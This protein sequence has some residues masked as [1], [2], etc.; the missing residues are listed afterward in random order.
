M[1]HT[2][3]VPLDVLIQGKSRS[4]NIMNRMKHSIHDRS[5]PSYPYLSP[6][7]PFTAIFGL[8]AS[9]LIVFF[10]GWKVFYQ[11]PFKVEDFLAS[12]LWVST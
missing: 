8:V 4:A 5:S 3:N 2:S 11:R 9:L 1:L 10:N 12:Y 7:Q 6:G